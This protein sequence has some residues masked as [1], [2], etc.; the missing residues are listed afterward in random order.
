MAGSARALDNSSSFGFG[1]GLAPEYLGF[2][3]LG[4]A[5]PVH[6]GSWVRFDG[7]W[8]QRLTTY[9]GLGWTTSASEWQQYPVSQVKKAEYLG[10]DPFGR[11]GTIRPA[12]GSTHDTTLTYAGV[13]LTTRTQ[14]VATAAGVEMPATRTEEY[15]RQGRLWK[16]TEPDS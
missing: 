3:P 4:R 15:D 11:P 16:V 7:S 6:G 5:T 1:L 14:K 10:F 12:D 9:N 8:A 13:R 2:G